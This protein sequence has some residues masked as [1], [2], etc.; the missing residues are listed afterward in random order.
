ML[1]GFY[2]NR[3]AVVEEKNKR[4]IVMLRGS[5]CTWR[6]CRFCDYHLDCDADGALNY[7]LN[8]EQLNQVR[9]IYH[10][11][12]VINSGSFC[13]LDPATMGK[14]QET[15]VEKDITEVHFECHWSMREQVAPLR[16]FFLEKGISVKVKIG[17]ET[18][19]ALF[20]ESYLDKGIDAEE[21][22]DIARWFDE[23]CLLQGIPGQTAQGMI[24]DIETALKHFERVCV[25]IMQEN[26][27]P[28][29]PDPRVIQEF[30][31]HVNP[32]YKENPRVDILLEN[33]AFG[34][35]GVTTDA[36]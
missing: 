33:T 7:T 14:I 1:E 16:A 35:G 9:G 4:E 36:Q 26:G 2:P 20:R 12:E 31:R 5:G 24:L 8:G 15:C 6:R 22:A 17:V 30:L 18:F 27:R 23:C 19:D 32:I 10:K 13:E 3:Y 29:K 25:N 11:L 34:V 21:P 28:V